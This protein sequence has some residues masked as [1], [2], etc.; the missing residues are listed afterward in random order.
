MEE[1][2]NAHLYIPQAGPV[3]FYE[4]HERMN[5]KGL[6]LIGGNSRNRNLVLECVTTI[7]GTIDIRDSEGSGK[8]L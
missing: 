7:T 5:V 8:F 6:H 3:S 2:H 4:L 1:K